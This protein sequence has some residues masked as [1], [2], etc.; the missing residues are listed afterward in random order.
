MKRYWIFVIWFFTLL[1]QGCTLEMEEYVLKEE[2]KGIEEAYTEI[3]PV[4]DVTYKYNPNVTPLNGTV[5][6]YI[7][8]LN[9]SVL[10]LM[11][12]IPSEWIP[13]EGGYVSANCSKVTPL[14]ISGKV[15]SVTRENGMIRIGFSQATNDEIFEELVVNFDVDIAVPSMESYDSLEY[16]AN[17]LMPNDSTFIDMSFFDEAKTRA[18]TRGNDKDTT[19]VKDNADEST[20]EFGFSHFFNE[21]SGSLS[22]LNGTY[23][24]FNLKS[25]E[26]KKFHYYEDKSKKIKE[27]WSDTYSSRSIDIL[28]GRGTDP[29]SARDAMNTQKGPLALKEFLSKHTLKDEFKGN[30]QDNVKKIFDKV[31]SDPK[32]SKKNSIAKDKFSGRVI[33]LPIPG[34][35][36]SILLDFDVDAQFQVLG[37]VDV[38]Y[39]WTTATRRVGY[40]VQGDKKTTFNNE[41][42][43][44]GKHK[45]S[46]YFSGVA[47]GYIRVRAGAGAMVG[48]NVGG[49]GLIVGYE[50]KAGVRFQYVSEEIGT[51]ADFTVIDKENYSIVPYFH[52]GG[53]TKGVGTFCGLQIDFGDTNFGTGKKEWPINLNAAVEKHTAT[54]G[55]VD[56]PATGKKVPNFKSVFTFSGMPTIHYWP[57]STVHTMRPCVRVYSD[58]YDQGEYTTVYG[59]D[60]EIRSDAKYTINVDFLKD[61]VKEAEEY[62]IVPCI[63]DKVWGYTMEFRNYAKIIG[64]QVPKMKNPLIR[65]WYSEDIDEETFEDFKKDRPYLKYYNYTQFAEYAFTCAVELKNVMRMKKWGFNY[66]IYD[67]SG[68][69][70]LLD[71]D[72]YVNNGE[73]VVEAG[74]YS[75][76]S[77]FIVNAKP[78]KPNDYIAVKIQPFCEYLEG[79]GK[80]TKKY[81]ATKGPMSLSYPYE[82]KGGPYTVGTQEFV[83][84]ND[85]Q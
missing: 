72:I 34:T 35:V 58:G 4:G 63:C 83:F 71:K 5:Q 84:L 69:S 26:H 65:Q 67:S 48:N 59:P 27:E 49:I 44:A 62:Y 73:K 8:A 28:M 36:F 82:R 74:K 18:L 32:Y 17:G 3:T 55:Y 30:L 85:Y 57:L 31:L 15:E 6:D 68:S 39:K 45:L 51:G 24:E 75:V 23:L 61:G 47:D 25:T 12:N 70:L 80:L 76:I 13:K 81:Y 79:D 14:G 64:N 21:F 56:D 20:F 7:V 22:K 66:K 40:K 53:Y 77:S 19:V 54:Y 41:I 42:V 37:C 1:L 43:A 10:Y 16:A 29:K 33:I 52:Y 78:T 2:E 50:V 9:D 46:G 38:N 11:D 60:D